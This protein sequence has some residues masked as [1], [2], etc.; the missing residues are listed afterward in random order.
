MLFYFVAICYANKLIVL[1]FQEPVANEVPGPI[2]NHD[3]PYSFVPTSKPSVYPSTTTVNPTIVLLQHNRGKFFSKAIWRLREYVN[4]QSSTATE[5]IFVT[6]LTRSSLIEHARISG[7]TY[8]K[9][10]QSVLFLCIRPAPSKTDFGTIAG[11][12]G[13]LLLLGTILMRFSCSN[14]T[15]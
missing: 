14:S 5:M 10:S 13:L 4:Y 2:V 3:K 8:H 11:K 15:L 6:C 1:C 12:F 9:T 7:S